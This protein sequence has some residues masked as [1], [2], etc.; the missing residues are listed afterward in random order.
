[1]KETVFELIS[2]YG[3]P[4]LYALL[5]AGII[6][7]PVPDET[8]MTFIGSLTLENGPLSFTYS[9]I[10]S[11]M[12]TMTGMM[13]SYTVGKRLGKPFLYKVSRWIRLK[14]E[15]LERA[16]KWFHK[17]GMWAIFFGY[18]V[19][20]L[21]HLTCY[22]AGVS[23]IPLLRYVLFAGSGALVWCTVFLSL[24]HF[25]G[26]NFEIVLQALHKYLGI[27]ITVLVIVGALCFLIYYILRK[28]ANKT[29]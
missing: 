3:Y 21:R 13:I 9:W 16:E 29:E 1:M 18:F 12:G 17:H 8:L 19:P 4:A 23:G 22:Y 15:K 10:V 20:G 11:Y 28:K 27:T 5:A 14:P 24:G 26:E 7:L 25:I 2:A 6:G